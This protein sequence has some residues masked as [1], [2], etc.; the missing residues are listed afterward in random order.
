[1][2]T[3]GAASTSGGIGGLGGGGNG[4][5]TSGNTAPYDGVGSAAA[6]NTGGGGGGG[7]A[8]GTG[9]A[10]G[11][12]TVIVRYTI[13]SSLYSETDSAYTAYANTTS[14]D[15][16]TASTG[17]L[18]AASAEHSEYTFG[19]SG[20]AVSGGFASL[21]GDYGTFM[22]NSSNGSYV[23]TPNA[24]SFNALTSNVTESFTITA[25][26]G[27]ETTRGTYSVVVQE[28]NDKVVL[29]DSGINLLTGSG[30][31]DYINGLAGDDILTGM[32]GNDTLTGGFGDDMFVFNSGGG[33]DT[34]TDFGEGNDVIDLRDF[35]DSGYDSLANVISHSTQTDNGVS[36]DLGNGDS[37]TLEGVDLNSLHTDDFLFV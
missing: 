26:A 15:V 31:A 33:A 1:V 12:G 20:G 22:I 8:E 4:A 24:N 23:F 30:L 10:G 7:D 32:A 34:I 3:N 27:T 36:I 29:G 16:F 17:M 21:V 35:V 11:S 2:N 6:A 19:V 28:G 25:S 5:R 9:G 37:V 13:D 14:T 18:L